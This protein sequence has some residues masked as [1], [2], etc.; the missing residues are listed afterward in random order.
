M[1]SYFPCTSTKAFLCMACSAVSLRELYEC[2]ALAASCKISHVLTLMLESYIRCNQCMHPMRLEPL[3]ASMHRLHCCP[4]GPFAAQKSVLQYPRPG[5]W[6]ST[7]HVPSCAACNPSRLDISQESG[8]HALCGESVMFL[9][10]LQ[11]HEGAVC[12]VHCIC[13]A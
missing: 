9:L 5:Q 7:R 12:H 8:K 4:P 11:D 3:V 6:R 2:Y 13:H 10:G 1:T